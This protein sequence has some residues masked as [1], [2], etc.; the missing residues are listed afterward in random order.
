MTRFFISIWFTF[1]GSGRA[2]GVD[3]PEG[4]LRFSAERP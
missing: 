1:D 2:Q 3:A 4:Y